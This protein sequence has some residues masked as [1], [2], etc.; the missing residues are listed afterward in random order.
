MNR[1]EILQILLRYDKIIE[2]VTYAISLV[3]EGSGRE[4]YG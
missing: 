2:T 1:F 4:I 3:K